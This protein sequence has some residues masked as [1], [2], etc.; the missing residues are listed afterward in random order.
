MTDQPLSWTP[1]LPDEDGAAPATTRTGSPRLEMIDVLRGLVIILMVLDHVREY[2]S[3]DAL[4]FE[5]TD[6]TQTHPALFATRWITHLCAPTFVFLAGV[7][8]Y[9]QR[10]GGKSNGEVSRFLLTRGLWLI[11]LEVTVITFAFNFAHPFLFLQV[12]WA[13]GFGMI[14]LAALIRLPPLVVLALGAAIVGG[15]GMLDGVDPKTLG[16]WAPAWQLMMG[17][18]GPLT[19]APGLLIYA[20]VPWFGVMCLGYGLG[21][22]FLL[23]DAL[24]R[25]SLLGLALA[26]LA[27]FAV[28]RTLNGYGDPAPWAQQK[29]WLFTAMSFLKVSKY[30]P[31]LDYVLATLG[32]AL[33]LGLMLEHAKG[34]WHRVMLAFGRTPLFT[35]VVHIF[36]IHGLALLLGLTRGIP[37]ADFTHYLEGTKRLA[38]AHWGYSLPMVFFWWLVVVLILYPISRAY[39]RL[40][41]ERRAPWMSYL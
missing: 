12:I 6:L 19:W 2:F 34:W 22:F 8:V 30:T 33:L 25:W 24:R 21:R 37:P 28:L 13:I 20:A 18:P 23:P 14:L 15:H 9:L 41:Q 4:R 40:K 26:M 11:V 16:E 7:S 5:A 10:E 36:L 35:Y 3:I 1:P 39:M 32:V 27:G 31:S 29:D 38:A 17:Q